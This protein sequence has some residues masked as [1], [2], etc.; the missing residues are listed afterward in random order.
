MLAPDL[1]NVWN[2]RLY[3][4]YV[5]LIYFYFHVIRCTFVHCDFFA[6]TLITVPTTLQTTGLHVEVN[7]HG[8]LFA[9]TPTT[10]PTILQLLYGENN[11]TYS[12]IFTTDVCAIIEDLSEM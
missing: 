11:D 1:Y 7:L 12:Y 2:L 4:I 10:L 8:D 3:D 9:L 5:I 6:L